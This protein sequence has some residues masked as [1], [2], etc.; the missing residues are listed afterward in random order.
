L[1]TG[2]TATAAIER[3]QA[4]R[5]RSI[6][7]VCLVACPEGIQNLEESCPDVRIYTAAVDEG[8]DENG[9]VIPGLGDVGNR[10]YGT[11]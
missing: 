6:K 11:K 1:A 5:P 7:F 10:F 3:I 8:L 4:A 9:Y 2:N